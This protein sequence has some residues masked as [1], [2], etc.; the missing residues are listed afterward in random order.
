MAAKVVPI[1]GSPKHV[2]FEP[3]CPSGEMV[4][5]A[6]EE[7]AEEQRQTSQ[8][9]HHITGLFDFNDTEAIKQRIRESKFSPYVYHVHNLYHKKGFFQKVAKA[10]LF[11][12]ITLGVIVAN[13]LWIWIDTDY[14]K[15]T[16]LLDGTPVLFVIM[17]ILFCSYFCVELFV[18]F[19]AFKRKRNCL[20][21]AWFVF[22][23]TLV[24]LYLFDPFVIAIMAAASG[25]STLALPT[26]ILRLCRLARLSRLVRMLRSLPEL[27]IMIKGMMTASASVGYTLGL[28]MII[29]YVFAIALVH[30]SMPYD[31]HDAY[32]IDV[33]TAMY[34]LIIYGCFLDALSDFCDAIRAESMPCLVCASLY[35]CLASMT[36]LNML[37]GVLCEVISAVAQEEKESMMV[38]KVREKFGSILLNLDQNNDGLI[39]WQEFQQIVVM[40]DA[41]RAL[42]SVDVDPIA[43]VDMCEEFFVDDGESVKVSFDDFMRMILDLRGGQTATLKDVMDLRKTANSKFREVRDSISAIDRKL[44]RILQNTHENYDGTRLN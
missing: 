4:Y 26:S 20:K 44:D 1:S 36:V 3:I 8:V 10:Q 18:R 2:A 21:D 40:P 6:T 7:T 17:D 11:D 16:N 38:D 14:N 13:A 9:T 24:T 35:I 25:G 32:F 5:V 12:N 27:M 29:T 34:S 43:M 15:G 42:E 30:L 22:D 28:L 33:P 39:C 23:T 41:L 19:M 31:F 37:I